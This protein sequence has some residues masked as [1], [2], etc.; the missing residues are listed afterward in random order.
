MDNETITT[1]CCIVGGGP[2]G[3]MLGFLLAR[4]GIETTVVE[5]WP[6]FFRDFR[7]DTL[8]PSTLEILY[9]LDLLDEFLQLPHNKTYQLSG[10]IGRHKV[11]IADFSQ[12]KVRCPFIAFIPQWDFLSF[13]AKHAQ[14]LST[15]KLLMHTEAI[16]LIT[17][18][19]KVA[20]ILAKDSVKIFKIHADLVIGADG[21]HSVIRAKSNLQV[22][23]LSAPM[24]VL[25]FRLSRKTSDTQQTMGKIDLGRMIVMIER[26]DY[27]QCGYLIRKGDFDTIRN[28]GI[29]AFRQDI[30]AVA[31]LLADRVQEL[32]NWEQIKL[33]TV[34]VDHLQ[35]WYRPGLLCIGDA[36][37]A[38]SPIGGVGINLAIQD[39]VAAAN[40]LLPAFKA[41][42]MTEDVLAAVQKRRELPTKLIQ[43]G[44]VFLQNRII[45]RVLG[46]AT[47]PKLPLLIQL[48]QW[49]PYLRRLPAYIVGVGVRP[50][51][52]KKM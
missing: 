42:A 1:R 23:S 40:I 32:Q 37:H 35:K 43:R 48:L 18:Q 38:M 13:I 50:E 52:I 11:I 15:F 16:D 10:E 8:H 51:H 6:D 3:I 33:L 12:L 2:A 39:A 4:A 21:R 24:D 30:I 9:E 31:P 25:W 20:G 19:G 29:A 17:E 44:Q 7:G 5:K 27:W 49:F 46:N 36:A 26:G 22:E 14:Q 47:H 34:V 28:N 41:N 45:A